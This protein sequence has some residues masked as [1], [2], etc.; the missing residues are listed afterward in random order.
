MF[1][2]KKEETGKLPLLIKENIVL[3]APSQ[4]K[5]DVIRTIGEK[6]VSAGYVD[7]DYVP[8]MLERESSFPTYMGN[9]IAL[10][11]GVEAAKQAIKSSGIAIMTFPEGVEW[12]GGDAKLVIAIAGKG[13]EHLEILGNI[14]TKLTD[15]AEVDRV[16]AMTVD[17][18]YDFFTEGADQ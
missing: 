12:S 7:A 13:D 16:L 10:P 17:E 5:D 15:P 11:H 1:F 8:A 9:G 2:K 3:N 4:E 6:L 18:V 14:A